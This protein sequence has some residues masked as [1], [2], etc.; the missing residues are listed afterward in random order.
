MP[1]LASARR[2]YSLSALIARRAAR[3]ARRV[4]NRG[5]GA[6]GAVVVAHQLANVRTSET[7]VAEMLMEQQIDIA[8]QA[9]LDSLAFTTP[10]IELEPMLE[11]VEVDWQFDRLVE[12]L[13]QDSARAAETVAVAVRPNIRHVRFVSPPCCARCAI[14]AGREYRFSD[15]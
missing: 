12:S 11:Q 14:L 7:A 6:V 13:V 2:N 8:A 1:T 3:E 5:A 4:R 10:T 15:G 9:I